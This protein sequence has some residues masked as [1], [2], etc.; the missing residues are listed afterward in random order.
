MELLY[1]TIFILRLLL[2]YPESL[3]CVWCENVLLMNDNLVAHFPHCHKV[4]LRTLSMA[5]LCK[6]LWRK[7]FLTLS[8]SFFFIFYTFNALELQRAGVQC[9]LR[10]KLWSIPLCNMAIKLYQQFNFKLGIHIP[11]H[12]LKYSMSAQL[13]ILRQKKEKN[14]LLEGINERRCIGPGLLN[15]LLLTVVT[16]M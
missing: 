6:E 13:N 8:V 4:C 15:Q 3:R 2:F 11:W 10:F 12:E 9:R 7:G 14:H 5:D 1:H 16:T